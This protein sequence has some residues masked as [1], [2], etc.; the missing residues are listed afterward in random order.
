MTS[1]VTRSMA[2]NMDR[3]DSLIDEL[4][5]ATTEDQITGIIDSMEVFSNSALYRRFFDKQAWKALDTLFGYIERLPDFP[6][7]R[8]NRDIMVEWIEADRELLLRTVI[9]DRVMVEWIQANKELL[10]STENT[11]PNVSFMVIREFYSDNENLLHVAAQNYGLY[12]NKIFV[13]LLENLPKDFLKIG[14][15]APDSFAEDALPITIT[16]N[17]E[18]N[19]RW[20]GCF[21]MKVEHLNTM[22]TIG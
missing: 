9:T 2:R 7:D 4:T 15:N 21:L 13:M 8:L 17:S 10:L 14:L 19:C 5:N 18:A 1:M 12:D 16:G 20:N 22:K 11:D 3:I 6:F